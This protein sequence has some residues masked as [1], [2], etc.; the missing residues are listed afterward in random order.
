[1]SESVGRG[2]SR[3]VFGLTCETDFVGLL[4]LSM[5]VACDLR[6]L[7][8]GVLIEWDY[9]QLYSVLRE[10]KVSGL[11]FRQR[12]GRHRHLPHPVFATRA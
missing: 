4:C 3:G 1:M 7:C 9:A 11:L 8:T 2:G 12:P 5:L 6:P 10:G